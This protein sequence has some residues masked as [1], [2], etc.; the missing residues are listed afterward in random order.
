MTSRAW[1]PAPSVR[2][3]ASGAL[4]G[5]GIALAGFHGVVGGECLFR[6]VFLAPAQMTNWLESRVSLNVGSQL[7]PYSVT[8]KIGEGGMGEVYRARDKQRGNDMCMW[9]IVK[10]SRIGL[11]AP[12]HARFT[13]GLE[14]IILGVGQPSL[15]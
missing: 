7:G 15:C 1:S 5:F 12:Q 11:T 2:K 13:T 6:E 14:P 4:V 3:P 10:L 8:A 9:G